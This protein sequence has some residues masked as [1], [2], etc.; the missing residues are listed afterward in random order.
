MAATKGSVSGGNSAA[1]PFLNFNFM[2][3]SGGVID[4]GFQECS[5]L[6][7][8]IDVIEHREGGQNTTLKKIPGQTKFTNVVLKRGMYDDMKL[9][10]W[11][12]SG[13][14]G[15][16]NRISI[17]IIQYDRHATEVARWNLSRAWAVKYTGPTFSA[18]GNDVA[19]ETLEIAHEGIDR[20]K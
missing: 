6:E 11:Y 7:S 2:I 15:P 20:V 5:G 19:I 8:S 1:D 3:E 18:E 16:P 10:A 4:G 9:F 17:S 13:V 12:K 14:E